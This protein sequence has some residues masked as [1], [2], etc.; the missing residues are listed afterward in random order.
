VLKTQAAEDRSARFDEVSRA[1]CTSI[2]AVAVST[3]RCDPGQDIGR[4]GGWTA[5]ERQILQ[6]DRRDKSTNRSSRILDI[7]LQDGRIASLAP[8]EEL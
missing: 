2:P 5:R 8:D 4:E 6:Y 3:G 7:R 1:P